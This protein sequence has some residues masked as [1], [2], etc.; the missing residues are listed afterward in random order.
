[1]DIYIGRFYYIGHSMADKDALY[2]GIAIKNYK[3][4]INEKHFF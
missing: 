4:D 3:G 1:M 2:C